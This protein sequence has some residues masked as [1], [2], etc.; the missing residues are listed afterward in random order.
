MVMDERDAEGAI[1]GFLKGVFVTQMTMLALLSDKGVLPRHQLMKIFEGL[2]QEAVGCGYEASVYEMM[3]TALGHDG[4][5]DPEQMPD[6]FR[7]VVQGGVDDV[8]D[9]E[10]GHGWRHRLG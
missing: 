3:L 1:G 5:P 4:P 2:K 7:G 9:E 8:K 6:W 10:A